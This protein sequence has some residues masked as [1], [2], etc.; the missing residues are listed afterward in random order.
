LPWAELDKEEAALNANPLSGLGCNSLQD[1]W[2]GGKV[3]FI[4]RLCQKEQSGNRSNDMPQYR[5]ELDA[6]ELSASTRFLRRW[7]S[8]RFV[9]VRIPDSVFYGQNNRKLHASMAFHLLTVGF[10]GLL[11]FF[12]NNFVI[13][14]RVFRAFYA[15]DHSVFLFELPSTYSSGHIQQDLHG[16]RIS[17]PQFLEWHNPMAI[18]KGQVRTCPCQVHIHRCHSFCQVTCKMVCAHGSRAIELSPRSGNIGRKL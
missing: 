13:H 8:R 14:G 1:D 9:R 17:L 11:T 6:P 15:K 16:D 3:A 7:G 2:Y 10:E 18:N 4:A 12:K 5:I